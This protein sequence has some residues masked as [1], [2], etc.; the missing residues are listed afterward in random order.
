MFKH[1]LA[2][3]CGA[4]TLAFHGAATAQTYPTKPIKLIVGYAP[5]GFT[6]VAARLI[7]SS[8]QGKLGQP[9]VVENR[10]GATGTIGADAVAKAAPDGYTLLL[11]HSNSNAVAPALFP[12]LPYNV[13]K[14]FTPI[15]RIA[16]TPLLLVVNPQLPAK[17]V[18]S[19]IALAKQKGDLKFAS[20][21][22]GSSQH[23]AAEQFRRVTGV[24]M[25]HV[26]Y[27]GSS[28]ALND[29]LAGNVDLN[30]DSPPPTL[31]FIRAGKL[32][33]LAI[34]SSTR[35]PL[36]PEVPTMAE[37]GVPGFEFTQ[38]FGIVGPANLPA[39]IVQRLNTEINAIL[40]NAEVRKKLADLGADPIGG[41]PEEFADVIRK[42]T[43]RM[44]KVIKDSNIKLD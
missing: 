24:E 31:Q 23:I 20:S 38:W 16:T 33:A 39:P 17:D 10:A 34:T 36:L 9:V 26:P 22:N 43:V 27:K 15:V 6:D 21:G 2:V 32:R 14:D 40:K 11:A 29:L 7:A 3:L 35:S 37:A 13:D 5:G 19:F 28:Q 12:K 4:A 30:F 25:I 41:T 8:L 18:K 1:A 44:A 42:D